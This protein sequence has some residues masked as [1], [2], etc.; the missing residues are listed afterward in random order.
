MIS[1]GSFENNFKDYSPAA[2]NNIL[3]VS[4]TEISNVFQE[5]L[6]N[7]KC[8]KLDLVITDMQNDIFY[9]GT[10]YTGS[11]G[12]ALYYLTCCSVGKNENNHENLKTA[13][14]YI[15]INNLKGRRISFLCGDAGPLALATVISYKLGTRRPEHFPD[16]RL[17]AQRLMSLISLLEES[18]DELLYGKAGYL[19][20]L[21][22]VMKHITG[23]DVIPASHFEKVISS[24]IKSGKKLSAQMKFD[25]PLL[26]EWHDKIYFGA[27]HGMT[28]ILYMLLQAHAYTSA[29]EKKSFIKPTI[30]WLLTHRFPSGNFPSSLG[31]SARDRL[32]QWCHGATGF[33]PLCLLAYQIFEDDK[34]LKIALQCGDVIWQRGLCSKGYSLCHGVSGNAYAFIQLY[35]A[36]KNPMHLYRACCFMEWC[37]LERPGTELHRPD[38]PASL[39]EGMV[40]RIY[41]AEDMSRVLN[42][43]FPAFCL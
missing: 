42:A 29:A 18:P 4:Q 11:A 3:T 7:Y 36:T 28:G 14:N 37:A 13:L 24:I 43:K 23:K 2:A 31:S 34:Y 6:Q 27:A 25:T 20:S 38:R 12:L 26:W 16:Y 5:K 35:Q 41:L 21:L 40:G 15:D 8:S 33:V 19:Y 17:L 32:V 39:F 30:D 22:F 10:I 9:D 1:K